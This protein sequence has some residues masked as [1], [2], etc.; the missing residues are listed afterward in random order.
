MIDKILDIILTIS[1]KINNWAWQK[2]WGREDGT[3]RI[4]K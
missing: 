2:R 4:K 3:A 1:T